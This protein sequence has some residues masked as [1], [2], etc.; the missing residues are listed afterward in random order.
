MTRYLLTYFTNQTLDELDTVIEELRTTLPK[1][2][3]V[4]LFIEKFDSEKL[5]SKYQIEVT[6]KFVQAINRTNKYAIDTEMLILYIYS[7]FE[8]GVI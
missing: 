7:K 8:P 1:E 3:I 2:D 5:Y 6:D 4:N